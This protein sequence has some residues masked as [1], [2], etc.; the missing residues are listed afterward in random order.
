MALQY[1]KN[2]LNFW[3]DK[4]SQDDFD[5]LASCVDKIS[6]NQKIGNNKFLLIKSNDQR[7]SAQLIMNIRNIIGN[8][9]CQFLYEEI[10]VGN[11]RTKLFTSTNLQP[12]LYAQIKQICSPV[13]TQLT[14][15]NASVIC[16]CN[17]DIHLDK[18]IEMRAIVINIQ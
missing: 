11:Y 12:E 1:T 5:T 17:C 18:S 9:H 2:L 16:M 8:I 3:H 14:H 15:T 7:L 4:F 10:D 13:H 6:G